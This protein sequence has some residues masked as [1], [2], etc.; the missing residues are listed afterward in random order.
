MVNESRKDIYDFLYNLFF[1]VVTDNVYDMRAPQE[2]TTSDTA[3]GF[4]VIHVGNIVDYSEFYGQTYGRVRC[5]I[6][7]FIPQI[8]RGRVDHEIYAAMENS[9]TSVINE[10]SGVRDG[11][12]YIER[13]SIISADDTEDSSADNAFFA[14]IKSFVIVIDKQE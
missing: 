1:G 14:F 5:Y 12:F 9:I 7:A 2:L 10:Q 8:S 3:E 11:M 4:I 13:D 6:E